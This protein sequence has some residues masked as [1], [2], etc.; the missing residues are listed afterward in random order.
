MIMEDSFGECF[1]GRSDVDFAAALSARPDEAAL[2]ALAVTH[3]EVYGA[4]PHPHFDGF[5]LVLADLANPGRVPRRSLHVRGKL[6]AG[7]FDVNPVSWHE[8]ARHC[9][10]QLDGRSQARDPGRLDGVEDHL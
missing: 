10:V 4:Y 9:L 6:P 8:L 5:H 3:A 1:P 7:R 2:D